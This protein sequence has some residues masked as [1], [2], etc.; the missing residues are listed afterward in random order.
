MC[1]DRT[2]LYRTLRKTLIKKEKKSTF[3]NK[4]K[5]R[6]RIEQGK[7]MHR[8]ELKPPPEYDYYAGD[9]FIKK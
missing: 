8:K 3:L 4:K 7:R 1:M 5:I 6:L 2:H 9:H